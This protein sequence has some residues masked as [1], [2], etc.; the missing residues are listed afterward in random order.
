MKLLVEHFFPSTRLCST[1]VRIRD[2]LSVGFT[3]ARQLTGR[4]SNRQGKV[5]HTEESH[6]GGEGGEGAEGR[7]ETLKMVQ[8]KK[9]KK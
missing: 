5:G 3:L 4:D 1:P 6:S 8:K 2:I 9:S 7:R